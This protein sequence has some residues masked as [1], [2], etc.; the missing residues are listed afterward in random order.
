MAL[1]ESLAGAVAEAWA[2]LE[3]PE[4][5][6]ATE[7]TQERPQSALSVREVQARLRAGRTVEEVA[8]EAGVEPRWVQ[9]FAAPVVA[10]Q[11]RMVRAVRAATLVKPRL[12]PSGLP[13]GESVYRNLAERGLTATAEELD[14]G[15]RARRS[16]DGLWVVAFRYHWRGRWHEAAWEYDDA[17][18][19]V[20]A[21]DRMAAQLAYRTPGAD[22]ASKPGSDRRDGDRRRFAS[23]R[24]AAT[25]KLAAAARE[26]SSRDAGAAKRFAAQ[27][28]AE[29]RRAEQARRREEREQERTAK[30]RARDEAAR[31]KAAAE[32]AEARRQARNEAAR[33]RRAEAR[34]AAADEA[35]AEAAARIEREKRLAA[36]RAAREARKPAPAARAPRK[37]APVAEAPPAGADRPAVRVRRV[38]P[39]AGETKPV[40]R[41]DLARPARPARAADA[42]DSSNGRAAGPGSGSR[43]SVPVSSA[44]PSEQARPRRR[45]LRAR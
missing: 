4:T 5:A 14:H 32:A 26:A 31:A 19:D 43:T 21:R 22:P 13:V 41:S 35:R 37:A 8:A 33:A 29:A 6:E 15:W 17:S 42:P 45:P 38:D 20:R 18:H 30:E 1:D 25:T 12:G 34:A 40:F 24:K 9:R 28:V 11:A 10:E 39:A 23:A 27:R 2:G 7:P 44:S 36:A 3:A 16:A